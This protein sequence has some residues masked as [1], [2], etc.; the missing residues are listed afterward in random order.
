MRSKA[1]I[2][3]AGATLARLVAHAG[4]EGTLQL[5]GIG[6]YSAVFRA[7]STAGTIGWTSTARLALPSPLGRRRCCTEPPSRSRRL[8]INL[9]SPARSYRCYRA[10]AN[11]PTGSNRRRLVKMSLV[12][13]PELPGERI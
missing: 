7:G 6:S 3:W 13:K 9:P 2:A 1:I 11:A 10:C 5:G 4:F 12:G 8:A